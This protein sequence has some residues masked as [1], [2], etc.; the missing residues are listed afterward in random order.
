MMVEKGKQDYFIGL[1]IGTNSVGWAVSNLN[2][3][4]IKKNGKFLAGSR[5]FTE[6][7]TAEGRRVFRSSRRR[8]GRRKFR[9]ELLQRLFAEK[10]AE[11]DFGFFIRMKESFLHLDD[12]QEN[13]KNKFPLFNDKN[14][15]DKEFYDKFPTIYH[16]REFLLNNK[17]DDI[18]LLYLACHHI[19]KYRGH[20]LK[21]G[22]F[23]IDDLSA[24][25]S[26]NKINE[27]LI[28]FF[29]E[30][31]I[32]DDFKLSTKH[33]SKIDEVIK[34]TK[35]KDSIKISHYL[36]ATDEQIA[37]LEANDKK[38]KGEQLDETG[39]KA[40]PNQNRIVSAVA[41]N[42]VDLQLF[43]ID[44]EDKEKYEEHKDAFK[45]LNFTDEGFDEDFAVLHTNFEKEAEVVLAL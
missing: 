34:D 41:G 28:N 3:E 8:L 6:A 14:Y 5:L 30:D 23:D 25:D 19:V 37:K 9:L 16:L 11:K 10:I 40:K 4:V 39:F 26:I 12:K 18:R 2:Y 45:K 44:K 1:D 29:G 38:A 22:N 35:L 13:N 27:S 36:F 20:F 31:N 33:A 24:L 17:T 7:K 15:T 42:K 43:V 32:S 21:E